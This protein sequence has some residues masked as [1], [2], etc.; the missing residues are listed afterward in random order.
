M[1][2]NYLVYRIE[3][4]I[5]SDVPTRTSQPLQ[6]YHGWNTNYVKFTH[7]SWSDD[8]A[9]TTIPFIDMQTVYS[10]PAVPLKGAGIFYKGGHGYGGFVAPMIKTYDHLNLLSSKM[11]PILY[12]FNNSI[13]KNAIQ[14]KSRIPNSLGNRISNSVRNKLS[15]LFR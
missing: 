3:Q 10:K 5:G 2:Q 4:Q 13:V 8:A 15:S 7:T 9:Q 6:T 12:R 14:K 1:P 11:P